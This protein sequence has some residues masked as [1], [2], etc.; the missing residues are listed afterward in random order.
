MSEEILNEIIAPLEKAPN[1]YLP[2]KLLWKGLKRMG[3]PELPT[4]D[5]LTALIS[6]DERFVI[7]Y[8][9]KAPWENSTDDI[10]QMEEMGYYTGPKVRLK[11]RVPSKKDIERI[12]LEQVQKIID[13]LVKA[14]ESRPKDLPEASEAELLEAMKRAKKLKENLELSFKEGKNE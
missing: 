11:I 1:F 4:L 6:C 7:E 13:N 2:I 14:Y 3:K 9:G 8:V 10:E 12:A 5:V